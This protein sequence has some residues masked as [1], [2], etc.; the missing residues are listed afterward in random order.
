MIVYDAVCVIA[1]TAPWHFEAAALA[2][3]Y[4]RR[5]EASPSGLE[6]TSETLDAWKQEARDAVFREWSR[7]LNS[8]CVGA[9]TLSAI[10]PVLREWVERG[11]GALSYRLVQVL[12]GHGCFGS[13][14]H[15]IG[16]ES[17]PSCHHCSSQLDTALHTLVECPAW[18]SERR[19]LE[20]LLGANNELTLHDLVKMM[21][22]DDAKWGM[23]AAFCETIM[24]A[25]E[26]AERAR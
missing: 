12:S 17:A 3:V 4:W 6:L 14:L 26:D 10:S 21:V 7:E 19:P 23:V 20:G 15:R 2:D 1:E 22:A 8:S 9:W 11:W 13:Y 5:A 25:K 24:K 18:T 16:R